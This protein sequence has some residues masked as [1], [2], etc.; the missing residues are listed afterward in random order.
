MSKEDVIKFTGTVTKANPGAAFLVKIPELNKDIECH[1][2][3]NIR[4]NKIKIVIGD[5]VDVEFSP[6]DLTKGRI[7]F[8]YSIPRNQQQ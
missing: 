8:R 7:S 4:R 3:G 5:T 6:Y 2:S 1:I